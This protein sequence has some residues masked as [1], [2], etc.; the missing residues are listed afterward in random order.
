MCFLPAQFK[1]AKLLLK[2]G[3]DPNVVNETDQ[4]P[5]ALSSSVEMREMLVKGQRKKFMTQVSVD[6][7]YEEEEEARAM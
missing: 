6:E 2:H 3:A 5:F 4:S 1:M 7:D